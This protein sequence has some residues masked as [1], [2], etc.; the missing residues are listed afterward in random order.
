M[1]I[2]T[3]QPDQYNME[4]IVVI[5]SYNQEKYISK[6]IESALMQDVDFNYLIYIHDDAST[7]DTQKI[8]KKYAKENPKR[9]KTFFQKEN[10]YSKGSNPVVTYMLPRIRSKYI[11][12]LNGDDYWTDKSKLQKQYKILENDDNCVI[13]HHNCY[14]VFDTKQIKEVYHKKIIP[15]INFEDILKQNKIS[16]STV[17]FR[18]TK[19]DD[20]IEATSFAYYTDRLLW[21]YLL[22][23]GYAIYLNEN[24]SNYLIHDKGIYSGEKYHDRLKKRLYSREK[25]LEIE[26]NE[27]ELEL[28]IKSILRLRFLI[29]IISL[30]K[31]QRKEFFFQVRELFIFN[32]KIKSNNLM[33]ITELNLVLFIELPSIILNRIIK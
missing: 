1:H 4:L 25:L 31:L 23:N 27:K 14:K 32:N 22:K 16:T 9:I 8:I 19:L 13:V 5:N 33:L 12:I 7:D 10:Q 3:D 11:A 20:F 21:T 6:A 24:L 28:I 18:N 15:T 29:I 17:L 26:F 30:I 2:Y